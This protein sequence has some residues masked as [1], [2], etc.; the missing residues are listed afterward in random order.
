[1]LTNI[2]FYI[3]PD[4]SVNIKPLNEPMYVYELGCRNITNEMI[5]LIRD[6]YPKAFAALSKIYSSTE[7]NKDLYEYKIVHRFI[8]CN[9]GEYDALSFDINHKG[10]LNLEMVKCPLRGECLHECVIC[11]PELNRILSD[12]EQEVAEL[13]GKGYSRQEVAD[14]LYI[15]VYTV[16]RHIDNIKRRLGVKSTAEIVAKYAQV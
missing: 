14:E 8:R 15:S 7:R 11:R 10:N 16:S 9:L 4:G 13:L 2:E 3:G 1:M 6:L 5:V 12:R